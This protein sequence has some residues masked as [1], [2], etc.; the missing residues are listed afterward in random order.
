MLAISPLKFAKIK[1]MR[2][3]SMPRIR[4]AR[5]ATAEEELEGTSEPVVL[6]IWAISP[7]WRKYGL[8]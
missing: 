8:T 4:V 1:Q 7:P 2:K 5:E 3:E 6:R